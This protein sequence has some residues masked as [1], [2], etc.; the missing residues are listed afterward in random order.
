MINVL[1]HISDNA[2]SSKRMQ[3]RIDART[4]PASVCGYISRTIL[5]SRSLDRSFGHFRRYQKRE[6]QLLLSNAGFTVLQLNY[7]DMLGAIAWWFVYR[8]L[9]STRIYQGVSTP[10]IALSFR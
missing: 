1:E 6:L 3:T 8:I 9:G 2:S 4:T 10:M 7:F 5:Q